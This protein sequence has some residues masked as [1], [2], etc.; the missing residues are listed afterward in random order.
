M[1][2]VV[3]DDEGL[4]A[5]YHDEEIPADMQD[6]A[7]RKRASYMIENA[8]ELDDEVMEAY[9]GGEEPSSKRC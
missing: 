5:N 2:A 4:G 6:K 7:A 8:V 3:W 9:L 1:K